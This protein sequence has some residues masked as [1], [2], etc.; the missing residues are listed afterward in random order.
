[1]PT[2]QLRNHVPV[3]YAELVNVPDTADEPTKDALFDLFTASDFMQIPQ[4]FD[5]TG[6]QI[7]CI[8]GTK[9]PEE[10][11]QCFNIQQE[12]EYEDEDV[13]RAQN[14]WYEETDCTLPLPSPSSPP[15]ATGAVA[16]PAM[17]VQPLTTSEV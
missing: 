12:L 3:W 17:S 6:A 7:A 15:P 2:K 8:I 10:I 9:T 5:L 11:R 13:V 4:L 16:M 1:L 14:P